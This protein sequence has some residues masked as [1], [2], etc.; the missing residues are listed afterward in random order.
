MKELMKR[1][2]DSIRLGEQLPIPYREI[3]LTARIMDSVFAQVYPGQAP[4]DR[5]TTSDFPSA[6]RRM[7]VMSTSSAKQSTF[8]G[9]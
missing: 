7:P 2:Y 5:G 8:G 1:F 4:V 9:Y 3:L 6:D